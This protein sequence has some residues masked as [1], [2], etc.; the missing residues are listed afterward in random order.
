[1]FHEVTGDILLTRAQAIAHGIAPNDHFDHGLALALRERW[2]A[3]ARDFRHYAHLSYPRPGEIWVWSGANSIRIINLLTQEG[4]HTHG[5]KPGHATLV[6][7]NHSLH[8]LR[9]EIEKSGIT[10]IAMPRLATG[11]GK[12]DWNDV[13]KLMVQQLGDLSIPI[14]LYTTYHKGERATEPGI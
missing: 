7:V 14:Y 13:H 10:S 2:P 12:L 5:A 8:K 11:V 9:H 1:M 6:N 4:E 3:L